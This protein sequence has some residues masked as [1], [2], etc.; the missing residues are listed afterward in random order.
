[1]KKIKSLSYQNLR[2]EVYE[3][4]MEV[5]RRGLVLYTF[6]NVSA[7]DRAKGL[8]AIKPSGVSYAELKPSDIV[9][10]DL[11]G[12][13]VDSKLKP[14]S[15]TKTHLHLYRH[16]PNI[17]GVCHTHSTHATAWSQ[18]KLPLPCFGTTHAD[19]GWGAIPITR[20]LTAK[21]IEQDYELETGIQITD[22]FKKLSYEAIEMV[23]VASHAPFTWG[24][25]AERAVFNAVVLE[26]IAKMAIY[27]K[28]INARLKQVSQALL[29]K[30]YQRKHGPNSY[31]GQ[32]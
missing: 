27:S 11:H 17:G 7:I 18:S 29:N 8:I 4:N 28:Q 23:L 25:N 12:K 30:H 26:E 32:K 2:D 21:Q 9:V 31:Y 15:D 6:G 13:I 10:L 16:F 14:S 5:S 24:K 20:G 1:M 19:Y 3:S 22:T